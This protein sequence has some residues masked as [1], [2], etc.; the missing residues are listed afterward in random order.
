[1]VPTSKKSSNKT[2]WASQKTVRSTLPAEGVVLNVFWTG[3]DGCFHSIDAAFNSGV[4]WWTHVSSLVTIR[5]RKSLP[6]SWKRTR[7]SRLTAMR[8]SWCVEVNCRGT[9]HADTFLYRRMSWMMF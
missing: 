1:M 6:S 9:H 2:P 5:N 8:C 7:C 3:D 4:K